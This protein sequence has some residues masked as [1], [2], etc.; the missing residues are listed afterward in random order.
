MQYCV[1]GVQHWIQ[2]MAKEEI[3]Q[4]KKK[5]LKNFIPILIILIV[6][7]G[8]PLLFVNYQARRSG[9]NMGDAISRIMMLHQIMIYSVVNAVVKQAIKVQRKAVRILSHAVE[10]PMPN[11]SDLC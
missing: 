1:Y 11:F 7:V 2:I 3:A 9:M 10:T 4:K 8:I 6:I 5:G